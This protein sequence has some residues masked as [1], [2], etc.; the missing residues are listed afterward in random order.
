LHILSLLLFLCR[1][2]GVCALG[3]GGGACAGAAE[4]DTGAN[5]PWVVQHN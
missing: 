5:G 4:A 1:C 2:Q 3:R